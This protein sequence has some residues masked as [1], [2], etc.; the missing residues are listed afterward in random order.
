MPSDH[1]SLLLLGLRGSGKTTL[2][3]MVASRLGL[4]FLDLDDVATALLGEG[5]LPELW[6]TF[7]E[8]AFREAETRALREIVLAA[9]T[10]ARI[11]ALGGGTPTAPGAADLLREA[12]AER[13]V[14]LVYLRG[15]PTTLRAR[16]A[17][18]GT[19]E[20]PSLTGAGTLDEIAT[21][22]DAR[23]DLY[24]GLASEVIEIDDCSADG[25]AAELAALIG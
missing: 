6:A 19:A 15:R 13:R 5:S 22:F 21:V 24:R 9:D 23:D 16:L 8:A 11:V 1:P 10:P 12:A 20:R 7:G 17:G 25:L 18:A 4:P 14:V 3:R 2:G